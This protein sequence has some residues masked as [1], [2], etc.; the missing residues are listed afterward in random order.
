MPINAVVD[1]NNALNKRKSFQEKRGR[2]FSVKVPRPLPATSIQRKFTENIAKFFRQTLI[3]KTNQILIPQIDSLLDEGKKDL[4]MTFVNA[5]AIYKKDGFSDR[6]QKIISNILI[7]YGLDLERFK[8]T[9]TA[10]AVDTSEFN[11][12]QV[13]KIY[14]QALSVDI[15]LS[16]P[17]LIETL[18][19]FTLIN[20]SF[21]RRYG[22]E[23]ADRIGEIALNAVRTGLT[24]NEAAKQIRT[25]YRWLTKNK[26]KLIARDQ[27]GKLD[28]QL[29][30]LRHGQ[31]GVTR[32]VW[33]TSLDE[34]VRGNPSGRYPFAVP[35]HW[36]LEGKIFDWVGKNAS[37]IGPPGNPILCRCVAEPI[38]ED[39][40]GI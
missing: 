18:N 28:G 20:T 8:T 14:K 23:Y 37:P 12:K 21:L 27:I 26:A 6:L 10:R 32:Y 35:S 3:S 31:L 15:F 29:S 24:A 4:G 39:I 33:R 25:Q 7:D 38:L 1:I 34:R 36:D 11:K 16:E 2:S 13:K 9:I 22:D 19:S 5:D 30:M 17:Y 40:I